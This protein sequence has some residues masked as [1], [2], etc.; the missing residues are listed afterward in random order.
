MSDITNGTDSGRKVYTGPRLV[1]YGD[2]RRLTA[3]AAGPTRDGGTGAT[4][5]KVTGGA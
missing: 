1:V 2:L 3:G 4:K 5:S